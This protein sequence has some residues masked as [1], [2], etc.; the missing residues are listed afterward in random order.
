MDYCS[1]LGDKNQK[2]RDQFSSFEEE[3]IVQ[4]VEDNHQSLKCDYYLYGHRHIPI[5]YDL[6]AGNSTYFNIGE[7][8][9][10]YTYGVLENGELS[11]QQYIPQDIKI[12][13]NS[14]NKNRL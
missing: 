4:F 3:W 11:L 10:Y 8:M 1:K 5:I 2:E 12:Y 13:S 6:T 9:N 7:W 14:T